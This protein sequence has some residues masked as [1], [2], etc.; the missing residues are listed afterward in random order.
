MSVLDDFLKKTPPEQHALIRSLDALIMKAAPT[1][2]ASSKWGNLTYHASKNA[3]ALV[4][5]KNHVNLQIWGGAG[6]KD[7]SDL[8]EGTGEA[9]RHIKLAVDAKYDTSALAAIVK[10]AALLART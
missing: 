4:S 6:L 7:P 8:L 3:C 2:T 9:M 1:L 5:H 10:Q